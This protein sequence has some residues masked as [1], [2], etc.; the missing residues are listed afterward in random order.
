MPTTQTDA[1]ASQAAATASQAAMT[2]SQALETATARTEYDPDAATAA[3]ND[4]VARQA[5][6]E[7]V[8][9]LIA[10][11]TTSDTN[12]ITKAAFAR[13]TAYTDSKFNDIVSKFGTMSVAKKSEKVYIYN[14]LNLVEDFG[15]KNPVKWALKVVDHLFTKD[16]LREG[17]LEPSNKTL[18]TCLSPTRVKM[19]KGA[20]VSKFAF[21]G[22]ITFF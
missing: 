18:L 10:D 2:A 3:T 7:F 14:D 19:M 1:T 13:Y 11:E 4:Q 12:F 21:L 8:S 17:V 20:M 16:E 22:D 9:D 6:S 15:G 5:S